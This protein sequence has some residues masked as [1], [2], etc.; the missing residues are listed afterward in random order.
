MQ[1]RKE[2]QIVIKQENQI[3]QDRHYDFQ[4]HEKSQECQARQIRGHN[5]QQEQLV[6][7]HEEIQTSIQRHNEAQK[8]NLHNG[9]RTQTHNKIQQQQ[10]LHRKVEVQPN[11]HEEKLPPESQQKQP[12]SPLSPSATRKYHLSRISKTPQCEATNVKRFFYKIYCIM[13][14]YSIPLLLAPSSVL[15]YFALTYSLHCP[16][17]SDLKP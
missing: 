9:D 1:K 2:A 5:W 15:Y 17:Q 14:S 10:D 3:K 6:I 8:W 12:V 4:Q 16:P 11:I 13:V 7:Q